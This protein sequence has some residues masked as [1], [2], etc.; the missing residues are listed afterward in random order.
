[1][2]EYVCTHTYTHTYIIYIAFSL[3]LKCSGA[4][5]CLTC[6]VKRNGAFCN[7]QLFLAA[8]AT[9]NFPFTSRERGSDLLRCSPSGAAVCSLNGPALHN[10]DDGATGPSRFRVVQWGCQS[11]AIG[12][13]RPCGFKQKLF[14]FMNLVVPLISVM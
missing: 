2:Y 6:S 5:T 8:Q 9:F 7:M 12:V 13:G 3:C 10:I 14:F 4:E 11:D 1:M